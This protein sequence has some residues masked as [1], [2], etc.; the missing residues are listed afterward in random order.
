MTVTITFANQ[1]GGVGKTT[2]AIT[3]AHG[4]ANQGLH[5]LLVDLDSQG[6]IAHCLGLTKE[7]AL[8]RLLVDQEPLERVTRRARERLDIIP[9][10]KSTDQIGEFLKDRKKGLYRLHYYARRLKGY[11]VLVFDT[12]PSLSLLQAS[13]IMASD[14]L[15]IPVVLESLAIDGL[16]ELIKTTAELRKYHEDIAKFGTFILPTLYERMSNEPKEQFRELARLYSKSIWPPIPRDTHVREAPA[17]HKTIW[18][19]APNTPAIAYTMNGILI[20]GYQL[21]LERIMEMII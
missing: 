2:S 17:L 8:F 3:I 13:A 6:H 12:P 5:V 10:D 21:I 7:N 15:V 4:L 19:Y 11:D 14:L 20:G 1:K 9:G 16:N 18:E